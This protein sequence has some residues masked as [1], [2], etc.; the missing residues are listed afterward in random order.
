[1]DLW[2]WENYYK[3]HIDAFEPS[4]FAKFVLKYINKNETL[5][6]IGC[7][8]GRDSIFFANKKINA[9]GIDQ[10]V[11]EIEYLK[12]KYVLKNLK[13][14]TDDFTNLKKK[15]PK[16]NHLYS[17]FSLHSVDDISE[18]KIIEWASKN[19]DGYFFI[20]TRSD[21]DLSKKANHY[22]R[23]IN[24]NSLLQKLTKNNFKIVY[25]KLSK[26][27]SRYKQKYNVEGNEKNPLVIRIVGKK[28]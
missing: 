25:V 12:R 19:I 9:I 26:N 7:G 4:S 22:R 14:L 10:C 28:I 24:I 20:E 3:K 2:H 18:N 23:L 27:F 13:F 21:K 16:I 11:K 1:M 17:R 5:L 8:N 6:D 15:L